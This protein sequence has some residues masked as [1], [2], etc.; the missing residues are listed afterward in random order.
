MQSTIGGQYAKV[1]VQFIRELFGD[2]LEPGRE[3]RELRWDQ[4]WSGGIKD[5]QAGSRMVRRDQGWSGGILRR[6]RGRR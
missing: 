4:G 6:V 1:V 2:V 3:Q 5:G